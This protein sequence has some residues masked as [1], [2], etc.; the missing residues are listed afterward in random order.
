MPYTVGSVPFLNASP[1]VAWFVSLGEDSPVRVLYDLPSHLPKILEAGDADAILVSSIEALTVPNRTAAS[2]VCIGSRGKAES[3]RLF[4]KIPIEEIGTL[5]LDQSSMT[6]NALA[7]VVLIEKFGLRPNST[8]RRPD[9]MAMIRQHDAALL[10]GDN[11]L[12]AD[13]EGLYV[14]D[15]G[16]AWTEI[17]N[18]PFVWALW[19]GG[20]RLTVELSQHL[21]AALG[22]AEA[23]LDAVIRDAAQKSQIDLEP[24]RRYLTE[25]MN[26][27]L[28][29]ADLAGLR[30]FGELV[31]KHGIAEAKHFPRLVPASKEALV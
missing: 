26:Y 14:L 29:E 19:L 23:N 4:S 8:P 2:G 31:T 22:W 10:I 1:L 17:T 15:L 6:S 11:G 30:R 16:E 3:V 27:R 28:E 24:A 18:L 9:L 5:A 13:A 20:E 21:N 25:T 7:K 12:S